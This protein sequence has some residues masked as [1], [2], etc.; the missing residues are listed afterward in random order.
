MVNYRTLYV[1]RNAEVVD[2]NKISRVCVFIN[3][4]GHRDVKPWGGGPF[5]YQIDIFDSV[6]GDENYTSLRNPHLVAWNENSTP[7]VLTSEEELLQA[8]ASG[9]LTIKKTDIV[10]NV[11]VVR[12]PE[13]SANSGKDE[14]AK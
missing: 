6:P 13:E 5:G 2:I 12:W 10:V 9:E 14:E 1:P 4:V 8:E 11:P 7:R 3:G